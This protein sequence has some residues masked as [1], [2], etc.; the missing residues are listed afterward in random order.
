MVY[1]L[2]RV[3]INVTMTMQP[4]YLEYV[5]GFKATDKMPTAPQIAIVPLFSYIF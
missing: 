3:S 2:V 4:F 5:T 1:M